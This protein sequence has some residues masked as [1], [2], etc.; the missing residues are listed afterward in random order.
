MSKRLANLDLFKGLLILIVILGHMLQGK[1]DHSLERT[2]IYSFHMPLFIGLSGFLFRVDKW[3]KLG[4]IELLRK[5]LFRVII[6]W[7]IAVLVYYAIAVFQLPSSGVLAGLV[8]AFIEPYYH[9]WYIPGFLSWVVMTWFFRRLGWKDQPLI[10][11]ALILSIGFQVLKLYPA[12]YRD[13]GILRSV[14]ELILHTFRPYFYFFFVF[15]MQFNRRTLQPP[16]ALDYLLPLLFFMPVIYLFYYP[17]KGL[18]TI[19]FFLFNGA[20]LALVIKIS[21]HHL[22]HRNKGMEW[23]GRHSLAIYLWHVFPILMAKYLIGTESLALFYA[24]VV[25]LE[26]AFVFAYKY[27][28]RIAVL[29]KYVFGLT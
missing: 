11:T 28:L 5:Y 6:P 25:G 19:H 2:I 13:W 15:G 21:T 24:L 26:I 20:L 17:N 14:I 23:L 9:L 29:R 7:T 22:M 12:I 8:K 27:L 18:A 10:F 1:L 3:V 4:F 16:K